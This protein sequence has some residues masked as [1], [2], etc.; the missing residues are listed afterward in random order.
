MRSKFIN[1]I[2]LILL[3]IVLITISGFIKGALILLVAIIASRLILKAYD[4]NKLKKQKGG[5]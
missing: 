3:S 4:Y 2:S 1:I 5:N